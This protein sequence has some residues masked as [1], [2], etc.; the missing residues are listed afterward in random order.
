MKPA[1]AIIAS[2]LLSFSALPALAQKSCTGTGAYRTCF[3][4][5]SGNSYTI[6]KSGNS[7]QVYGSNLNNGTS[8]NQRSDRIG[9]HTF[10]TGQNSRGDAWNASTTQIGNSTFTNGTDSRGRPFNSTTTRI[11]DTVHINAMDGAGRLTTKTCNAYG[12][13]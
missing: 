10:T 1:I 3:D 12:C 6:N 13:F 11:G 7:T 4:L 5:S 9:N 8:W 2:L